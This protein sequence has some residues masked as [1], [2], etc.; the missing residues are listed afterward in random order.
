MTCIMLATPCDWAEGTY[1]L[2]QCEDDE[3]VLNYADLALECIRA[4]IAAC[5]AVAATHAWRHFRGEARTGHRSTVQA[6]RTQT[7]LSFAAVSPDMTISL[8]SFRSARSSAS[9]HRALSKSN[10][11]MASARAREVPPVKP[12]RHARKEG[13]QMRSAAEN[14]ST[15]RDEQPS[16]SQLG[17]ASFEREPDSPAA[18]SSTEAPKPRRSQRRSSPG[19]DKTPVAK[20]SSQSRSAPNTKVSGGARFLAEMVRRSVRRHAETQKTWPETP[21]R[22][23]VWLPRSARFTEPR[24]C[25]EDCEGKGDQDEA[26]AQRRRGV[27][28]GV[29]DAVTVTSARVVIARARHSVHSAPLPHQAAGGGKV[30]RTPT[31]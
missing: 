8:H 5:L 7:D 14:R 25:V 20:R 15:K 11:T 12:P 2:S 17:A 1:F 18:A 27:Q 4:V 9:A 13:S 19:P 23:P 10:S 28:A 31:Y 30:G 29:H 24:A 22:T 6:A 26:L 16:F 21:V 3:L